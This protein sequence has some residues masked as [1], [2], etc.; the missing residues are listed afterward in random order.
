MMGL[1]AMMCEIRSGR[2]ERAP[3]S[4]GKAIVVDA[5]LFGAK[6]TPEVWSVAGVWAVPP[7]GSHGVYLPVGG[8]DR[9]GV[10]VASQNYLVAPPTLAKGETAIG[11]TTADGATIKALAVAR[12]DG[13]WEI[14]GDSKRL[15]L[16][17]DL[18]TALATFLT[19]LKAHLT[20]AGDPSAGTLTLDISATKTT[21]IKTGG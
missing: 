17:D 5:S 7:D 13:T 4:L 19:A 2:I 10:V 14:N 9:F 20:A 3:E 1:Y 21:T 12:A 6:Y 18:T 8:S 15:V 16:W 11:S